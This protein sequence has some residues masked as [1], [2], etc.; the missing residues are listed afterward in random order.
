MKIDDM[1]PGSQS[2]LMTGDYYAGAY[3]PTIVLIL[4]STTACSWL[5]SVFRDL[6]DC[7]GSHILTIDPKARIHNIDAIEMTCRSDGPKVAIRNPDDNEKQ[8]AWS[9]TP[10]GWLYQADLI[11]P[12]CDGGS[13][14]Q[15]LTDDEDDVALI[16]V[17]FG[18]QDVLDAA[19]RLP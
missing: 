1:N 10:Q 8:F 13:G 14:H 18:E 9:A 19:K 12:F 3:G 17:S 5:Q 16:E 4:H 2:P 15:Y 11:Q 7:D 6:A